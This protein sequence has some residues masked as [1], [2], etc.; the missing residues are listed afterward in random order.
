MTARL[1]QPQ[2]VD[3]N[4]GRVAAAAAHLATHRAPLLIEQDLGHALLGLFEDLRVDGLLGRVQLETYRLNRLGRQLDE[5]LFAVR[6]QL[7]LFGATK[8][9]VVGD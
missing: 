2:Q 3:E 6:I 4:L 9:Y 7:V 8:Q 5:W 1:S